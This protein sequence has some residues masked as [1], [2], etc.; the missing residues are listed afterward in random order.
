ML[1]NFQFLLKKTNFQAFLIR[2]FSHKES[3]NS[4]LKI[5]EE[6]I[7]LSLLNVK[8][9]GW[10]ENCLK[11]SANELGYTNVRNHFDSANY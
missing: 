1:R 6:I 8:K 3:R 10:T 5:K 9:Y 7:Q 2:K 4:V 11:V